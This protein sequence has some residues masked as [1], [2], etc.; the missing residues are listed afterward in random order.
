MLVRRTMSTWT[1]SQDND[2]KDDD[3]VI[4]ADGNKE[5]EDKVAPGDDGESDDNNNKREVDK[6]FIRIFLPGLVG[7]DATKQKQKTLCTNL[8]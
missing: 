3:C 5:T 6:P 7:E 2:D 4:H 8:K 1:R